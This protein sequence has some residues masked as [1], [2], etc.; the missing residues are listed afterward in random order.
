VERDSATVADWAPGRLT[1]ATSTDRQD[2]V[3]VLRRLLLGSGRFPD[4]LRT[5]LHAEGVEVLE[6][7][8]SGSVT[9]R[10]YRARTRHYSLRKE[11]VNGAIALTTRRI[12]VWCRRHKEVDI[13][14]DHA[15]L[16][17]LS[18]TLD[19]PERIRLSYSAQA[20]HGDRS[21]TVELRFT[22]SR[23]AWLVERLTALGA[24]AE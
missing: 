23:A 18:A 2:V 8:L 14:V 1:P 13:P 12:V 16:G 22:T 24:R 17:A 4:E 20:F 11:A 21:G 15:L 19:K 9:F 6:E 10:N 3:N 7:G 5:S